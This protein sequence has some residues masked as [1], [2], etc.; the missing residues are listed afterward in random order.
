MR[1]VRA[2]LL[3]LAA[4]FRKN[5]HD[6]E[7]TAELDSHLQLHIDDNLRSGMSAEQARRHALMRLGGFETTRE[8]YRDR[9]GLPLVETFLQDLRFAFRALRKSPAFAVIAILTLALGIGANT[10]V[11]SMVNALLLHPYNFRDLDRL[12]RVWE[13]R[14]VDEGFDARR[15][16]P[17][18]ADD[19][20]AGS[21]VFESFTTYHY[22]EF[23]LSTQG[24]VQPVRA[25]A[26]S[27]D[28]FEVLAVA[29]AFGRVFAASEQQPGADQVAVISHG[30]W[31]RQFA[32]DPAV[33][34]KVIRL[35]ARNYTVVGVMP[36][37]FDFPVP[38]ELWV[39]LALPSAEKADR[40]KLSLELLAR[41][42]PGVSV[43]QA[44]SVLDGVSHRL[45]QEFPL[46]NANRRATL[47]PL[48]QE[49]YMYT[50]PLFLLLQ[51]AA[52]FV[53]L[54]ACSNLA[55]LLFA[56]M[57]ARQKEIAVR[58]ALGAGWWRLARL[59]IT[60]TLLL[61]GIAGGTA[62][63][64]S[65]WIIKIL[66]TSIAPSWTMWVPG[67][68]GI[69]VDR[70]VLAFTIVVV[71]LIGILFGFATLLH[72]GNVEPFATLK[73]AV[74]GSL[75]DR[76][77]KL[78]SA[79]VV[80]QVTLALILLVCAGLTTDAFVRLADVYRGFQPANVLRIE[81]SLSEKSYPSDT[82]V[83][84]F[85]QR[86]LRESSALP[87]A[88]SV[89]LVSNSPASN[90]DNEITVFT[91][92]GRA[93]LQASE[94]PSA[95]LQVSS[96]EYFSA[97]RV[98]LLA[99]RLYSGADDLRAR[100]VIVISR[101]MAQR[102]WPNA[103]ALGQ[104]LKLGAP[105]S[106]GPWLTVIGIVE[107]V[108]QNWWSP[109]ARPIIYE[110]FLQAPRNS[111]VFL[112]RGSANPTSYVSSIRNL[113]RQI[114]D[115][116]A[117]NSVGTLEKEITDSIAIIR[118]MGVLM[119]V[120]GGVALALASLGVYGVLAESVARRIPEIGIRLAL[121]AEPR[122]LLRL[123]LTHALKLTGIGLLIGVPISFVLN[124]AMATLV[125]GIVNVNFL[126]LAAFTVLLLLVAL[127]A[128]YIPARRAMRVD[129]LIA[130]RY[131]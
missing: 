91:V 122:Q 6:H 58:T 16:A 92:E 96:P 46:T 7:F 15:I 102:F 13:D 8:I 88:A 20:R 62:V 66:R 82:Q 117:L 27:A 74:R 14:G 98:P 19:I 118:V 94:A 30:F 68:N 121:G 89:A 130:L 131:E 10:A 87:G 115:Q 65:F 111:M 109:T 64:A 25:C 85:Y 60:E 29:P 51:A 81:F 32:A 55:N 61:C 63:L 71:V 36:Q 90:V 86:L 95:E 47:L 129:P 44:R 34:G 26:V 107:D 56:R 17:P 110:P 38:V 28:F 75:S 45:Q 124:R 12:V 54:L 23:N 24:N 106:S 126:V 103:D 120:F 50:L 3:R 40:S 93:A 42:R 18:D 127:L 37:D 76:K 113:V 119:A 9:R 114:D 57:F 22:A 105:N 84:G 101:S 97:L 4:L 21:N 78:R 48:R 72:A 100:R 59:F 35:N 83:T 53:L 80:A 49:L 2:A 5:R 67:W 11:F 79:L 70:N 31:Q 77:G 1:R 39:P 41:L 52:V 99:G 112:L 73:D 69:Q 123:I 128:A 116:V 125:F 33:L 108:R 43:A 104:R